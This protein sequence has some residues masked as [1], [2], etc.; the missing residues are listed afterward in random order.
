M[1][2]AP[3]PRDIVSASSPS[4]VSS[5]TPSAGK[6]SGATTCQPSSRSGT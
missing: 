5:S 1:V 4:V 2:T 6:S 3:P